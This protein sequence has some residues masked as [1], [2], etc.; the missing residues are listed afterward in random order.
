MRYTPIQVCKGTFSSDLTTLYTVTT[1]STGVMVKCI[2]VSNQSTNAAQLLVKL[3]DIPVIPSY[4]VPAND[5]VSDSFNGG[6]HFLASGATI[7]G[8]STATST[9]YGYIISGLKVTT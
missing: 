2:T 6:F 1:D 8:Q 4:S 7:Q 5:A 9:N 3:D